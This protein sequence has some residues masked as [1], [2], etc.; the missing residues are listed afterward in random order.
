MTDVLRVRLEAPVVSFRDP[1]FPDLQ[2][3]LPLVPPSTAYGLLAGAHGGFDRLPPARLGISFTSQGTVEDLETYHPLNIDGRVRFSGAEGGPRPSKRVLLADAVMTLWVFDLDLDR[4]KAALRRPIW[5][6]HLGRSQDLVQVAEIAVVTLR[7]DV[8]GSQNAAIVPL[9]STEFNPEGNDY[10]L[11]SGVSQDRR[12]TSYIDVR[13]AG[14]EHLALAQ[15]PKP[16]PTSAWC[17]PEGQLVW[18]IPVG[19]VG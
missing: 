6:L 13:W 2:H 1:M 18:P 9:D 14:E 8:A 16:C 15:S 17:D 3:G 10:R 12:R 19:L 11:A 4:A 7:K 5:A